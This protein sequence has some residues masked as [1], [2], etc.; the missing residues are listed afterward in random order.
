MKTAKTVP[1][2]KSVAAFLGKVGDAQRRRDCE[3][4]VE[5][6]SEVTGAKPAMWGEGL[7][8]FGSYRYVHDSGR[9]GEA[10]LVAFAPRKAHLSIHILC[11]LGGFESLLAK[12][13]RHKAAQSC[14][15]VKRLDDVDLKVLRQI[16]ARGAK[17]LASRR[18]DT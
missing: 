10:P 12:L 3:V 6:M 11:G 13:G 1:S 7:V 5:L 15:Y 17:E 4:L 14:L 8:G 9:A 2:A 18:T 16:V